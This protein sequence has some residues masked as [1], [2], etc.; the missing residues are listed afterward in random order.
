MAGITQITKD[1]VRPVFEFDGWTVALGDASA[2]NR[3]VAYLRRNSARFLPVMPTISDDFYEEEYWHNRL[4]VAIRE[5][6]SGT[7]LKLLL[8]AGDVSGPVIG[9]ISYTNIVRGPL[10]GCYLGFKLDQEH[11]GHEIMY[12]SLLATNKFVFRNLGLHRISANYMPKNVR[13]ARLLQRLN[14]HVEGYARDYLH[15]NGAWQ[16]HVLTAYVNLEW[17]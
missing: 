5:Y 11:E 3:V 1:R 13:S 15:L 17:T 12:K 14:F 2:A 9:D 10:Q 6:N 16:D 7:A 8:F 4:T